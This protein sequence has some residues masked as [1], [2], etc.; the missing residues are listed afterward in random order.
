LAVLIVTVI[1]AEYV[2]VE[3]DPINGVFAAIVNPDMV[4]LES[5]LEV[6]TSATLSATVGVDNKFNFP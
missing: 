3:A 1:A 6:V 5:R 2:S 4:I